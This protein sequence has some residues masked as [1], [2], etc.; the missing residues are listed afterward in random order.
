[1]YVYD[2]R[3]NLVKL[4]RPDGKF[5]STEYNNLNKP[6]KTTDPNGSIWQQV[7]NHKGL[8]TQQITPIGAKSEYEYDENGQLVGFT[9]PLGAVTKLS[10]DKLGNM[11]EITDALGNSTK[12]TFDILGNVVTKTDVAGR[13][14]RYEYDLKGRF[15]KAFLPGGTSIS[16]AYDHG[17]NLTY[18]KDKNGAETRME[19]CGMG[20]IKRFVQPDGNVVEYE[21]D[22]EERLIAVKNQKGEQYE[23]KRDVLGR[24][25]LE[26]DYWGQE[27][28][29]AYNAAGHLIESIDPLGRGVKYKTDPLGRILEKLTP[30]QKEQENILTETFEYDSNGNLTACENSDIRIEWDYDTDGQMLEERQG[31]NCVISNIYDLNGNRTQRNTKINID[32]K[33][34]S[35]TVNINYDVLGQS[36]SVEIPGYDPIQFTRNV[37]GQITNETLSR[38]LKR[39][40][41]YNEDGYITAQKVLASE[42]PIFEQRYTY[43]EVGNLIKKHDSVFGDDK[44]SYDPIGRI[45]SHVN[46]EGTI[47]RYLHDLVGDLMPT[48]VVCQ[49]EGSDTEWNREGEYEGVHYRFDRSGNLVE[50]KSDKETSFIWDANQRLVESI[51]NGRTTT[52]KY[53]PLGRRIFKETDGKATRFYWDGNVLLGDLRMESEGDIK[54]ANTELREFIYYPYRFEPLALL[55]TQVAIDGQENLYLYHNDI[56]GCPTR[57]MEPE[58]KVVWAARYD[59]LGKLESMP[60]NEVD[61]PLRLQGQYFDKETGLNYNRFRYFDPNIRAYVSQ[62]PLGVVA[63]LNVYSYGPNVWAWTDP[64]GLKKHKASRTR[65]ASRGTK[66]STLEPGP[67]AGESIPARGKGRDFTSAEREKINQI[68]K[69]TGC[70]TCGSTDPG[71]KSGNFIPDHQPPSATVPDG[72]PQQLYP[73]CKGCSASQGGTLS[74]MKR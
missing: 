44:F 10:F 15:T 21:Y 32:G 25:T 49:Q 64:L 17:D 51:T 4:I 36:T 42:G 1:E 66:A 9:D 19:Y 57:L 13:T 65:K 54:P 72:T 62:D 26:I 74:Q 45:T 61:N 69:D 70:H 3:G 24:I 14:T 7:W 5:V 35:R 53:D 16:C 6:I 67:Y 39:R 58:G 29:Y 38:S 23:L 63:D 28:K 12:F 8:L 22:M 56:N 34:F 60:V 43:D 48:R 2:K 41:D 27:R 33:T 52:Y 11:T 18:F 40:Y 55:Q 71:T 31:D 20:E 59:A 46:P 73:H 30:D 47:K 50:R 68:G 37:L